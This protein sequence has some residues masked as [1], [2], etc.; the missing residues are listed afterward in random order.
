MPRKV[1][2][3]LREG[4]LGWKETGMGYQVAEINR[5]W[6]LVFNAQ[7][8]LPA[9]LQLEGERA[10]PGQLSR[11][12]SEW[13]NEDDVKWLND[14]AELAASQNGEEE[15]A[16]AQQARI[17]ALGKLTGS[18]SRIRTHGSYASTSR[19]SE[20]FVRYSAFHPD[21]R[22]GRNGSVRPGTYVTTA[23]D[24]PHVP[25]GMA[26]VGRYALPNPA[27]AL[28]IYTMSPPSAVGLQCGTAAPKFGQAGGGVEVLFTAALPVGTAHGPNVI[29]EW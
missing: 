13:L 6:Y 10:D 2:G 17:E 1:V 14:T 4:L 9:Q 5:A 26:A 15:P 27:P 23:T 11:P 25:S 7:V 24:M 19:P 29:P 18:V 20:I 12:L 16:T 28:Y 3:K 21:F 22:I 8:A